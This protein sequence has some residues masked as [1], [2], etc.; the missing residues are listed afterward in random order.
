MTNIIIAFPSGTDAEK[1]RGILQRRGFDISTVCTSGSSVLQAMQ[2]LG[3]GIVISGF[4]FRDMTCYQLAEMRPASFELV[5]IASEANLSDGAPPGVH[6]LTIPLKLTP[7]AELLEQLQS[8][9][10]PRNKKPGG[11]SSRSRVQNEEIEQVKAMLMARRGITEPE[12]H[13]YLQKTSMDNGT[14]ILE[15]ARMLKRLME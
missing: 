12:A 7:L 9:V 14:G 3:E 2:R 4:R 8:R 6:V 15:T 10:R 11:T 13:K 5:I 1:I